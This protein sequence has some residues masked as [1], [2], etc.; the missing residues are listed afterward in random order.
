MIIRNDFRA[1]SLPELLERASMLTR[2]DRKY[3]LHADE[4][5]RAVRNLDP[6]T[7]VLEIGGSRLLSYRSVYFDTADFRSYF[8]A[9]H[10][11][12]I[13]SKVRQRWYLDTDTAFTEVKQA[14]PRGNTIKTRRP[15]HEIGRLSTPH[16]RWIAETTGAQNLT[17]VIWNSYRRTTLLLPDGSGR[18]TIDTDLA[19]WDDAG[20]SLV[21]PDLVIIETK[22]NRG[23]SVFDRELWRCGHRPLRISKFGAGMA[24]LHPEFPR[25]RWNRTMRRFFQPTISAAT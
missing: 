25:H 13:R 17:A 15:V 6:A 5:E 9:A 19:W 24:A 10:H 11:R 8:D 20:G 4:V 18:A 23:N 22:T 1:I 2:V 21:L 3:C 12:R 16:A 14:G 7:Q